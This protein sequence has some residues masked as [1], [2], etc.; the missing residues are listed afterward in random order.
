MPFEFERSLVVMSLVYGYVSYHLFRQA[1]QQNKSLTQA[2]L[3]HMLLVFM[4]PV[5]KLLID[6]VMLFSNSISASTELFPPF[7]AGL[8]SSLYY[9]PI[10]LVVILCCYL[11]Q[12]LMGLYKN[13]RD[14]NKG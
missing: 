3:I 6:T 1:L 4:S 8:L 14:E 13:S 5:T 7:Y 9:Y 11:V 12:R 10:I 2:V